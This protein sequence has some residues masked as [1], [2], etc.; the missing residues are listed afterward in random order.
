MSLES[1]EEICEALVR[2]VEVI[3]SEVFEKNFIKRDRIVSTVWCMVG[4]NAERFA[5]MIR[6][7]LVDNDF[8]DD[9]DRSTAELFTSSVDLTE[10]NKQLKAERRVMLLEIRKV[11]MAWHS[12]Q[13]ITEPLVDLDA[14]CGTADRLA[15]TAKKSFNEF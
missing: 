7:W 8:K 2:Y 14:L 10:E 15:D 5:F 4:G 6:R 9:Q 1:S 13:S 12:G 11:L 3:G